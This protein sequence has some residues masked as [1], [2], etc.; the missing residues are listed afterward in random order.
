MLVSTIGV[1]LAIPTNPVNPGTISPILNADGSLSIGSGNLGEIIMKS[2]SGNVLHLFGPN[3]AIF[4]YNITFMD[5][6]TNGLFVGTMSNGTN[7]ILS[8]V[9]GIT[10]TVDVLVADGT[11]NRLF[12]SNGI[13]TNMTVSL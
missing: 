8:C 5:S 12:I 3:S 6:P 11:T 2:P 10:Q 9:K 13:I 7:L 1:L 4:E